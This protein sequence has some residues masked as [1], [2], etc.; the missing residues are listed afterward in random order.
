M[1]ANPEN[2]NPDR[3]PAW[4]NGTVPVSRRYGDPYYSLQDGLAETRHVFLDGN[5]LRQR[6]AGAKRFHIAELG[7][8]TGLNFLTAW[9][10]WREQAQPGAILNFTSF[11][12]APLSG[13]EMARALRPWGELAPLAALLLARWP[14]PGPVALPGAVLEVIIGDARETLPVWGGL[15][16]AWFLDG[17]APARNPELWEPDVLRAVHAHTVPGGTAASYSAAGHVRRGLA[18]AGFRVTKSKGFG[19]KRHMTRAKRLPNR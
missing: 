7:F 3:G 14:S 18:A 11:E 1:T 16:D 5:D 15:A 10:A 12:I 4:R 9:H 17:F 2:P 13:E 8:G 19:T 6:F